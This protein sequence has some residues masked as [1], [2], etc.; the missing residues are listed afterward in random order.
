MIL[1]PVMGVGK[2]PDKITHLSQPVCHSFSRF[3]GWHMYGYIIN[4]RNNQLNI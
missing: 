3:L 4:Q 1:H 2:I